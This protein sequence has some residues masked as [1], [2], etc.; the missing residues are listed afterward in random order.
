[1]VDSISRIGK[2]CRRHC[3]T[4][5][6]ST[7]SCLCGHKIEGFEEYAAEAQTSLDR[8]KVL[9]ERVQSTEQLVRHLPARTRKFVTL[10]TCCAV[11]A[12][13]RSACL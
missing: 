6:N 7:D 3:Q 12:P 5:C 8:A 1:M 2:A 9:R 13:L 11:L 4:S 10:M